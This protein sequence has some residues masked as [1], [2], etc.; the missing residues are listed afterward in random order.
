MFAACPSCGAVSSA[1]PC[2]R[3][4]G[5]GASSPAEAEPLW[6]EPSPAPARF[7]AAFLLALGVAL[8]F[9]GTWGALS[10]GA[11]YAEGRRVAH[12]VGR[13]QCYRAPGSCCG[14]MTT[15]ALYEVDGVPYSVPTRWANDGRPVA[16]YYRAGDPA[17]GG[18]WPLNWPRLA[19]G[20]VAGAG[21][22]VSAAAARGRIAL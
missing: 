5:P 21:L 4:A 22:I 11:R 19:G 6:L 10:L 1:L 20:L 7:P 3:C 14:T 8:V 13:Y 17:G 2:R 9:A 12:A 18:E 15:R 16:I